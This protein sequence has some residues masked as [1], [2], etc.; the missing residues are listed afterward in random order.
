MLKIG[1][2]IPKDSSKL[3]KPRT[4]TSPLIQMEAGPQGEMKK[5]SNFV[6][7]SKMCK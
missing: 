1:F 6:Q 4:L 5:E 7:Q 2:Q 3:K